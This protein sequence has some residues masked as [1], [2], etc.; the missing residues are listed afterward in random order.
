MIFF[1]N[2]PSRKIGGKARTLDDI[3]TKLPFVREKVIL[4]HYVY[5]LNNLS[6]KDQHC[7]VKSPENHTPWRDSNPRSSVPLGEKMTNMYTTPPRQRAV[8]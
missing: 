1:F 5:H 2:F 6:H 3:E 7:N 8:F 4:L